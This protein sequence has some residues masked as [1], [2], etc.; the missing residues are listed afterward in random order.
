M[1][2]AN[3]YLVITG[4]G[5]ADVRI[6]KKAWVFPGQKVRIFETTSDQKKLT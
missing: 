2:D 5:V 1:A 3:S 4:W 6:V